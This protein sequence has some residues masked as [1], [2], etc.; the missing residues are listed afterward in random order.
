MEYPNTYL[1]GISSDDIQFLNP[2]I[3]GSDIR[4]PTLNVF[5]GGFYPNEARQDDFEEL[6]INW[7]DDEC[8]FDV[9]FNQI[10][11]KKDTY[12]FRGGV[13]V[14]DL[15]KLK[16]IVSNPMYNGVLGYE[17]APIP[18]NQYH[19]NILMRKDVA[20]DKSMKS[21]QYMICAS[22]AVD[23]IVVKKNPNI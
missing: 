18:D 13:G 21:I 3:N 23:C 7:I 16:S 8:A 14:Y 17:R 4:I 22:I 1:R 12:Q 20:T 19:G 10:N 5:S 6:S 11:P 9:A 2:P 15:C